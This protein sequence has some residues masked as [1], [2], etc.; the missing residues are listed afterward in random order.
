[1]QDGLNY[2]PVIPLKMFMHLIHWISSSL[3]TESDE[4]RLKSSSITHIIFIT[5]IQFV[6]PVEE[7]PMGTDEGYKLAKNEMECNKFIG[8]QVYI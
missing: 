4:D 3:Y 6:V 8:E 5:L 1:M 7:M 2:I